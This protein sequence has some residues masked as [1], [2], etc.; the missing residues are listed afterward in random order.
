MSV[1]TRVGGHRAHGEGALHRELTA[2][3]QRTRGWASVSLGRG[4]CGTLG[5]KWLCSSGWDVCV[6]LPGVLEAVRTSSPSWHRQPV[7]TSFLPTRVAW[8]PLRP[9]LADSLHEGSG[10]QR[11]TGCARRRRE[12]TEPGA[13]G[14]GDV[15]GGIEG[16]YFHLG[17]SKAPWAAPVSR[18]LSQDLETKFSV[19]AAQP[20]WRGSPRGPRLG[21]STVPRPLSLPLENSFSVPEQIPRRRRHGVKHVFV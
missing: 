3:A 13:C 19:S 18:A 1:H 12:R 15:W 4:A 2:G 9:S 14:W 17:L 8:P 11:E 10:D 21:L 5:R 7:P 16:L 20:S 6:K